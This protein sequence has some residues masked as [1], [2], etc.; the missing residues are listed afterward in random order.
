MDSGLGSDEGNEVHD[1]L[2]YWQPENIE[3]NGILSLIYFFTTSKHFRSPNANYAIVNIK[4]CARYTG[5]IMSEDPIPLQ[6]G[7]L[8]MQF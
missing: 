7:Q 6:N 3:N 4:I 5:Q 2:A 8:I 1:D